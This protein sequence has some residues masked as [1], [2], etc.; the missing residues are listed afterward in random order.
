M[1]SVGHI[2]IFIGF[3]HGKISFPIFTSMGDAL[4][5]QYCSSGFV[6]HTQIANEKIYKGKSMIRYL[7]YIAYCAKDPKNRKTHTDL[8]RSET[9]GAWLEG[10]KWLSCIL[11]N[12]QYF[13]MK[14]ALLCQKSVCSFQRTGF[15]ETIPN[16]PMSVDLKLEKIS[17][18]N[19]Q[20]FKS[21][22]I[23]FTH[24]SSWCL[25]PTCVWLSRVCMQLWL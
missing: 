15:W 11:A 20:L 1:Y 7:C 14:S 23:N 3:V 18:V 8:I 24:K 4:R 2:I 13:E 6:I 10:S 25:I 12:Q 16:A 21:E 17:S 19:F 5:C 22:I 9:N